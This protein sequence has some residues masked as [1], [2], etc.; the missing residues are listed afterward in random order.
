MRDSFKGG[1]GSD[2]FMA[3]LKAAQAQNPSD[4]LT[5]SARAMKFND[6]FSKFQAI[7]DIFGEFSGTTNYLETLNFKLLGS[8]NTVAIKFDQLMFAVVSESGHELHLGI[9]SL[10]SQ[11]FLTSR[12]E[13]I[14]LMTTFDCL[15]LTVIYDN[16][17]KLLLNPWTITLDIGLYWESW[18]EPDSDPQVS[19]LTTQQKASKRNTDVVNYNLS[20]SF[21][22]RAFKPCI[23]W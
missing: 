15:T 20:L 3:L 7:K 22:T 11:L 8:I 13:K 5:V 14:T 19:H 17:K 9:R 10:K 6:T 16:F 23:I 18:Q 12:P 2:S 21:R 4:D 1:G